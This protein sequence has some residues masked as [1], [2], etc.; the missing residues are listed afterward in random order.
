ML[1]WVS[2]D[3]DGLNC[4]LGADDVAVSGSWEE[5]AGEN[6]TWPGTLY[7]GWLGSR[8]RLKSRQ[9][10]MNVSLTMA[11]CSCGVLP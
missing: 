4:R 9:S 2:L 7:W 10:P 8:I 1:S 6:R 11:I 3:P 5:G